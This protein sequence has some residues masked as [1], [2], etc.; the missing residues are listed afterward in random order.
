ME[1]ADSEALTPQ[2]RARLDQ[3]RLENP[4]RE[5]SYLNETV[6]IWIVAAIVLIYA[7]AGG[8]EAAFLTDTLQGIFTLILTLLLLPFAC[9]RINDV[10]GGSGLTGIIGAAKSSLPEAAGDAAVAV[11][12]LDTNEMA[13]GM[14]RLLTD[15]AL[16]QQLRALGQAHARQFDWMTAAEQT[17]RVYRRAVADGSL[18]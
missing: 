2:Q 15:S 18:T 8:L 13:S 9:Y 4:Q 6:L 1:D 12:P 11:D 5:F 16:R 7:I 17:A 10:F 14:A 3:L